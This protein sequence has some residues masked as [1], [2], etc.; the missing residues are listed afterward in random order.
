M[1][2]II[3]IATEISSHDLSREVTDVLK[4]IPDVEI[5]PWLDGLGEK[6]AVAVKKKPEIIL[7]EDDPKYGVIV[8]RI[9]ALK[10]NF[11]GA[12]I[13]VVS[14][15]PRPEHIVEAMKAGAREY[16][17]SP[18]KS[19]ILENAVDEV[20]A[21]LAS[22]GKMSRGNVFSFIGSKGGLGT[23]VL[24]VNTAVAMAKALHGAVSMVDM[25]WQSGDSSVLLDM[26]A[27]AGFAELSR[28]FHRLDVALL[29]GVMKK[30][31]TGIEYLGAP[32]KPELC[33]DIKPEHVAKTISLLKKIS[34]QVIIDCSSMFIN[35]C[36]IEAFNLS[37]RIF[38]V[39]ELSIP[40]VRNAVRMM[41]LMTDLKIDPQKVEVVVNRFE[42]NSTLSVEEAE[43]SLKKRISW[44]F[45]NDHHDVIAS[46]NRGIPLV[47]FLPHS[48]LSTN[49]VSFCK[50][51]V[52]PHK[53]DYRGA[54]GLFG[55]TV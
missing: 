17:I 31:S 12:V 11:N 53:E 21:D 25:S 54:R 24:A 40:S 28:N 27:D 34:D 30:H 37:N 46:I 5:S 6:G 49:V 35:E 51:L 33:E 52:N 8:D 13:F 16:L 15:D 3:T 7:V 43:K 18:I 26:E 50:H 22:A 45:P 41:G 23:T 1:T 2:N 38:V 14:P 48:P 36:V 4:K 55:Q 9:V 20:R 19:R 10:R 42:K 29:K 39:T 32:Y 47:H 44:L